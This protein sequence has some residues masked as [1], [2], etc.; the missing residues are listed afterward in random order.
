MYAELFRGPDLPTA[1]SAQTLLAGFSGGICFF[2]FGVLDK[3]SIAAVTVVNGVGSLAAYGVLMSIENKN[4]I[5]WSDLVAIVC[6]CR[7][8]PQY[9][10]VAYKS[11]THGSIHGSGNDMTMLDSLM[12]GSQHDEG[13]AARKYDGPAGYYDDDVSAQS[14]RTN[15]TSAVSNPVRA[16]LAS[17][18]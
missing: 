4:P 13:G 17:D 11:S 1:F 15:S 18:F 5:K 6:R 2:L 7:P 3:Q 16:S 8:T 9:K 14:S 10:F 12:D